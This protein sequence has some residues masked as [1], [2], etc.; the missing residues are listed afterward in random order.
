MEPVAPTIITLPLVRSV[1]PIR[2][3]ARLAASRVMATVRLLPL[4]M[5][6]SDSC[7]TVM[8]ASPTTEVNAPSPMMRA[9]LRSAI[10]A[11]LLSRS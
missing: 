3:T 7:A 9:P 4:V 6:M 8:P 2:I 5:A 10:L 1:A 11:A